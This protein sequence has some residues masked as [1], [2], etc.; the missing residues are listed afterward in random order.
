MKSNYVH[1]NYLSTIITESCIIERMLFQQIIECDPS[2]TD[3]TTDWTLGVVFR[4]AKDYGVVSDD[5][6]DEFDSLEDINNLR[7]SI[8]HHRFGHEEDALSTKYPEGVHPNKFGKEYAEKMLSAMFEIVVKYTENQRLAYKYK[9][10]L[11]QGSTTVT[12]GQGLSCNH[13]GATLTDR[14]LEFTADW[15]GSQLVNRNADC[16]ECG[17]NVVSQ[18]PEFLLSDD[19]DW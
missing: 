12:F 9:G 4:K 3:K 5:V 2:H 14:E 15:N 7:N 17:E 10:P 16:P 11:K 6:T 18:F 8:V 13:C 1:A 19:P